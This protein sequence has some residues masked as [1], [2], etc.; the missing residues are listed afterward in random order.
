YWS[1]S[2]AFSQGAG[3]A[4]RLFPSEGFGVV[5]LTNAQPIGA[6]EAI[7]DA[8]VDMAFTGDQQ[9]D[10]LK[11]WGERLA[12]LFAASNLRPPASPTPARAASAYAGSY[13]ND[14]Y[15]TI[16]IS[17]RGD[18]LRMAAGPNGKAVYALDHF[19]GDVFTYVPSPELPELR[20]KVTFSIG[21]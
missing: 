10:W 5:V 3:T 17:E 19:D 16:S 18:G 15:G 7:A 4:V 12:G 11:T 2:G 21:P 8:C 9:Q 13:A 20:A 14:Y 6:A 1:H